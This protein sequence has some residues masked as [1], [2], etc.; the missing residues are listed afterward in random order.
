MNDDVVLASLLAI[1]LG[2]IS[3]AMLYV[4]GSVAN[5]AGGGLW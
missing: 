5:F 4:G 2:C 3:L 1:A